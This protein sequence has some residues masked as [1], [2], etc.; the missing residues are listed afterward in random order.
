MV[1]VLL[2]VVAFMTGYFLD[3]FLSDKIDLPNKLNK[4]IS[5]VERTN[6]LLSGLETITYECDR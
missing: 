4:I 2:M 5:E 6:V 1:V 3:Y